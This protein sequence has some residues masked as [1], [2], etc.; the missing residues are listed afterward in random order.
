LLYVAKGRF[1]IKRIFKT[2]LGEFW[3]DVGVVGDYEG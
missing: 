1:K 2:E 3:Q